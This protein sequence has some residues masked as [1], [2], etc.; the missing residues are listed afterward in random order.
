[1]VKL[2][3]AL[4]LPVLLGRRPVRVVSAFAAVCV[5]SYVPHLLAVG[6]D[7]LATCRATCRRRTT[8][9]ATATCSFAPSG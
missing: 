8:A 7:V 6:W 1:M 5:L 9:P 4:L 3:P 2:Y